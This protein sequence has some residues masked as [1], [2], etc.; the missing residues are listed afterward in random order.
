MAAGHPRKRHTPPAAASR[1]TRACCAR[2]LAP[3]LAG[4][5]SLSA[6]LA[7]A[8]ASLE[9][10][11]QSLARELV[12]GAA[13]Q[14][15]ALLPC[16]DPLLSKPLKAE[17]GDLRALLLLGAYQ[18][19]HTRIPDHAA[20]AATVESARALGKPWAT[21]FLNAVLRRFQREHATR[22]ADLTSWQRAAHP[23]WLAE[24]LAAAYPDALDS[25]LDANNQHPP[26]WLRVNRRQVTRDDYLH[27]LQ[28]ADIAATPGPAP[29]SL[30][31]AEAMD[32]TRLPGWAEGAVSVQDLSAQWSALLLDAQPGD[33]VLDA[34]SAPGG[35]TCH[36]LE[37][38]PD[39]R[40]LALD[41]DADRL[42]RVE[43]NLRRLGLTANTRAADAAEP[44]RWWDGQPFQRI[45]LDAPCSATGVIRR[46]PDIKL[47]RRRED[48]PALAALQGRLLD[49]LWPCLEAGGTLLYA[50]CSVLPAENDD[51]VAAF[52][53]RT[54]DA[55][56][57][58][59]TLPDG[60]PTA[61]G[62]QLLPQPDGG[63][64]FFY[65]RLA[66]QP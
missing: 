46:H 1:D 49:A 31:L 63:D 26:L 10:R 66:K 38:T 47:T 35:K 4:Q 50:T 12:F 5:G 19:R 8:I 51:V 53:A 30:R 24:A 65:A 27:T 14:A 17:D 40:L 21:G 22:E 28:A 18:L 61:H 7:P 45:L 64:G 57:T 43:D 56:A 55:R 42:P 25:L 2:A 62:V 32:V 41:S 48:I 29:E 36:L 6:T 39:L 58:P 59:L 13:R 15:Y 3:V 16:I 60:R 20:L 37:H 9:P 52:L 23:R 44:Q 11:D 33:R 54:P 34:C